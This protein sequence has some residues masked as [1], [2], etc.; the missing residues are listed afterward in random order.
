[1][2]RI[3]SMI[4][5]LKLKSHPE[6]GYYRETYRSEDVIEHSALPPGFT[7][8][9]NLCTSIFFLLPSGERSLF[10]RI[11]SDELWYYHAGGS[12]TIYVL[13]NGSLTT[14]RLGPDFLAGESFQIVIPANSW[15]GAVCNVSNSFTL[16]GCTVSP[17]FDFKD[18]E[19]GT[20]SD[21]LQQFPEFHHEV[22]AL[23]K[24]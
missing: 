3:K 10:H 20:R 15:F 7:G 13:M 19:I 24:G 18:F 4:E 6:G 14:H 12:L 17:G 5:H 16:S 21:L 1:M 11:K 2:D 9:R 23:T 22:I 8:E